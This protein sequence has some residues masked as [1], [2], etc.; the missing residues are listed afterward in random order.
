MGAKKIPGRLG[1]QRIKSRL[2]KVKPDAPMAI[3]LKF[4]AGNNPYKPQAV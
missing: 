2:M 3:V 4:G 1:T